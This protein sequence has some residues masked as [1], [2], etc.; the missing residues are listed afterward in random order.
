MQKKIEFIENILPSMREIV[1]N[2]TIHEVVVKDNEFDNIVTD[3][4]KSIDGCIS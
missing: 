3:L 4:D 1:L 2:K